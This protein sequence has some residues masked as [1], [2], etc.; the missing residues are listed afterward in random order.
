VGLHLHVLP[1]AREHRPDPAWLC[2]DCPGW[3]WPCPTLRRC[4]LGRY[5]DRRAGLI[6]LLRGE[7]D[8]AATAL[9][10]MPAGVL[11]EQIVGWAVPR[12]PPAGY[13]ANRRRRW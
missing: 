4:L 3:K 10:G 6:E 5:R 1:P 12:Q 8:A 2:T 11:R 13:E 9:P 7:L